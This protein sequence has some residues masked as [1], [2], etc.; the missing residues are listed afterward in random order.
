MTSI[1]SNKTWSVSTTSYLSESSVSEAF[2]L[3]W[4]P[5]FGCKIPYTSQQS[6]NRSI[7]FK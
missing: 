1:Q 5:D 4:V 2:Q 7:I 6:I 3:G